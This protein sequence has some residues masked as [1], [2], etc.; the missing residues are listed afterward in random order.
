MAHNPFL[1]DINNELV[2]Q[3]S[4]Y[5]TNLASLDKLVLF[6]WGEEG[7]RSSGQRP[8]ISMRRIRA[9]GAFN[10]FIQLSFIQLRRSTGQ[11]RSLSRQ[12]LS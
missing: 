5:R 4:L 8:S 2:A 6:R 11:L 7:S 3:N 10:I 12:P 9:V 1:P